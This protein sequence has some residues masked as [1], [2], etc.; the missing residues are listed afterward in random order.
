MAE[1]LLYLGFG[2]FFFIL[3][4]ILIFASIILLFVLWIFML[5]D[6]AKRK[7]KND[8]D[9]VLWILVLALT[10]YI[11]AIIYYFV[12]KRKDKH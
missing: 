8:N 10:S 1:A 11:G 3:L 4:L 2:I 9:R 5:I 6:A 7:F 12:V